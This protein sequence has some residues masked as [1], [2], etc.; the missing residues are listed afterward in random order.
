MGTG[1]FTEEYQWFQD[2]KDQEQ[3]RGEAHRGKSLFFAEEDNGVTGK[4]PVVSQRRTSVKGGT[5]VSQE[6][7][8]FT[9]DQWFHRRPV[10]SQKRTSGFYINLHIVWTIF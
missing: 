6:T 9:G 4:Y 7:S 2:R 8:G 3:H 5:L 10:V 1:W